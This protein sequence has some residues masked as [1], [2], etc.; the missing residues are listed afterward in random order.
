MNE[1]L[2]LSATAQ[3]RLIREGKISPAE[4]RQAHLEHIAQVNPAI[5]AVVATIDPREP[6]EGPFHGVPF[7]IK[8][9]IE[10][11]GTVCTAGTTG[12][13]NALPSTEDAELVARLC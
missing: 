13:R 9:S 1:I 6:A 10:V 4:L 8:D 7:S 12:R 2:A 3:A 5:N 11:A